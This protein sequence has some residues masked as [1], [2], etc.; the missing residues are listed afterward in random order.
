MTRARATCEIVQTHLTK[1]RPMKAVFRGGALVLGGVGV[2]KGYK[3]FR[4]YD[5]SH[6][7]HSVALDK[8][9]Q[10]LEAGYRLTS[11]LGS[12]GWIYLNVEL[13]SQYYERIEGL[14]EDTIKSRMESVHEK[15]SVT[16]L[17]MLTSL[18]GVFIKLGQGISTLKGGGLP[19][20]Y[21]KT[22]S[23]LQDKVPHVDF[24]ELE[25]LV[26]IELGKSLEEIF[27]DFNRVPVASAS[28]AQV[29]KATLERDGELVDVAVKI[30]YPAVGYYLQ[31]D[32][33]ASRIAAR[34]LAWWNDVFADLPEQFKFFESA[35]RKELNFVTESE[36]TIRARRNF[37]DNDSVY[38]PRVYPELV[39]S[40]V[41][42]MEYINGV[43]GTDLHGIRGLGIT[44]SQAATLLCEAL[45]EQMFSHGFI[46]ADPHPGNVFFRRVGT[47]P[48]IVL[49][50]HGLYSFIDD[51]YRR[52]MADFFTHIVF[53][54]DAE[55]ANHCNRHG[56]KHPNL[57]A[58]MFI[59]QS[60]DSVGQ[61]MILEEKTGS[62]SALHK[63]ARGSSDFRSQWREMIVS[64]PPAV[65]L[66]LRSMFILRGFNQELGSN[67][68]RFVVMA[69]VAA[70]NGVSASQS[71]FFRILHSMVFEYRL[72]VIS[73]QSWAMGVAS[74]LVLSYFRLSLLANMM[75]K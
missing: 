49:L 34:M 10:S 14:D 17:N 74:H 28:L 11:F 75:Q 63:K 39:S 6:P 25:N 9:V 30:Q 44:T 53:K 48:Q 40:H 33:L 58:T 70:R 64:V 19:P 29:H 47:G 56:I 43:K 60:Y 59:I 22:L 42:T 1:S 57:F 50:D 38:V 45:A 67:I 65:R 4:I 61:G 13:S 20:A 41:L 35:L 46:H 21:A 32:L 15:Q 23:V 72:A 55:I 52:D 12:L 24:S 71:R 73:L 18:G 36:N 26:A 69:R 2:V 3:E 7:L 68:N 54:N 66:M 16:L 62:M 31:S 51:D 37:E 8:T 27:V 5:I